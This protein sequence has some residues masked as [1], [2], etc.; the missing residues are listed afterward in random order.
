MSDGTVYRVL[1]KLIVLDA[2]RISYRALDVEHIGSVYETMMGFRLETATG[3]S[4]AIKA[5][6]KHGAPVTINIDEFLDQP[7]AK[8]KG[9]LMDRTDRELTPKVSKAVRIIASDT[10]DGV[11]AIHAALEPVIDKNA[12]P[13]QVRVGAMVLQPSEE[14]RKS[15]SHYTPREL[16]EPIVRT[17][18]EPVLARLRAEGNEP[19]RPEQ[20]LNLKV[21]DPAMGSGAF[22]VEVCRQL[23]DALVEAWR[24]QDMTP[25]VP[26]DEDET[27]FARRLVAQRCLYGVDRNPKAVDLAKLSLWLTTLAKEHPLTFLDHA[28]RH[29]D[30]LVGMSIEQLQAFH[31]KGGVR[32]FAAGFE[33]LEG[34]DHLDKAAEL[35]QLIRDADDTVTDT[36]LRALWDAA[37]YEISAVRLLGDLVLSAF[38]GGTNARTREA[39]RKEFA[40]DVLNR[41]IESHRLRLDDLRDAD[42]PLV[43]FHWEIEF[44]EVFDRAAPGFDAIV[45]NPPFGGHV[46]VV[47]ANIP[48]YTDWL[49]TAHAETKGKCDLVAHFF[50]R[51]FN[52]IRPGGT[53]GLIATNTI[54][55]G[56]TRTSGL[57][58]ICNN[59]GHIYQAK[60]R[61]K[62]PGVAAVVV[63]VV[64]ISNG[65]H[66]STCLLDG[67]QC[68][69][70]TA[71]LLDDGGNDDP[72]RLRE[73]VGKGFQGSTVLGMGF[74]FDDTDHKGV[75]SPLSRMDQLIGADQRNR[76]L[77]FPYVG[78]DEL[79]SHPSHSHHRY[80]I[81][82][83]DFPLRREELHPSWRD[84]TQQERDNYFRSGIVPADY[85]DPVAADWPELLAIVED[86]V[87]PSRLE[88][89]R[90]SKSS[91]G[92][93]AAVWWKL[94][95][96]ADELYRSIDGLDGVLANSQVSEWM[97]FAFL[98]SNMV[99][100]HRLYVYPLHNYAAFCVMQSRVHEAW[101]L[102]LGSS[103]EDRLAYTLSDCFETFP[104]PHGWET[105][106]SIETTGKAY[107]EFRAGLMVENHEGMTA[108]YNRFHA[109]DERDPRI[110]EMRELHTAMDRALLDAYGW[111][112]ISTECEFLLDYEIDEETWGNKKK[113]FRYRWPD[114]VR[115]EVLA[116]LMKLNAAR[117]AAEA[118]EGQTAHES[119]SVGSP[120][121]RRHRSATQPAP[122]S[123]TLFEN[124]S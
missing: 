118:L 70:I 62:W 8:R 19:L 54:A 55:Q 95:H 53:L 29:G 80:V 72:A 79:N 93:R 88:A 5:G 15:G 121:S 37:D 4:I 18:L 10:A 122:G 66:W 33:A 23:A 65:D 111:H 119:T 109:P 78:G 63:S 102:F 68:E 82:F 14:R 98:P 22:L 9:W 124:S 100:A 21:C 1:E 77:I 49:R 28:F 91:H 97:Q 123:A 108:T 67:T 57:S 13:D 107:Y 25:E 120:R 12:T 32:V 84:S 27:I 87:K 11:D 112:D 101:S 104:F 94:Y 59:G 51:A 69:R 71:Y 116:R 16:T 86:K 24:V 42:P 74:T 30:S 90:K 41:D 39:R 38:F 76:E 45:G 83:F 3:P 110:A 26:P 17:A 114:H 61:L 34:R 81:N 75:A 31:W 6:K 40:T 117:A 50:R 43:P 7:P 56:D 35:R 64:H 105:L 89:A 52:L 46:T 36:E 96:R 73:N 85:P 92:Q 2:E 48:G 103:L 20:I 58:W 60:R 115:D 113:P 99:Y 44:P 106:Q 47:A